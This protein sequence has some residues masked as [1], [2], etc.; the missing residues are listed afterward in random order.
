VFR[1][2]AFAD[3]KPEGTWTDLELAIEGPADIGYDTKRKRILV[4][5]FNG[6]AITLI[7]Q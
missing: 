1:G 7:D 4:P 6:H 2:K 3:G 5:H